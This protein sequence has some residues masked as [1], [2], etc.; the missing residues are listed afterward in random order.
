[1]GSASSLRTGSGWGTGRLCQETW[2]YDTGLEHCT[3][4]IQERGPEFFCLAGWVV[5]RTWQLVKGHT[6]WALLVTILTYKE[7][8]MLEKGKTIIFSP[9]GKLKK[10]YL[11]LYLHWCYSR[12]MVTVW[13]FMWIYNAKV[14]AKVFIGCFSFHVTKKEYYM[15]RGFFIWQETLFKQGLNTRL[16]QQECE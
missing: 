4:W 9:Q 11:L 2:T 1:M 8:T 16:M 3:C 15:S 5:V 12:S 13:P 7:V 6:V 14:K 10:G